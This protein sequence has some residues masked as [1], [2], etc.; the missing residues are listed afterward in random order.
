MDPRTRRLLEGPIGPT[1][2]R[3]ALPNIALTLVQ[4]SIDLIE[5]Y[6]LSS[7]RAWPPAAPRRGMCRSD[8]G[9]FD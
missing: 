7:F 1:L 9:K 8:D 5:T 4:A 6:P 3:L 2:L